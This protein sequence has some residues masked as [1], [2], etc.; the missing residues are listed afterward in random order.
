MV[1]S[2]PIIQYSW[3]SCK[4]TFDNNVIKEINFLRLRLF[5]PWPFLFT[6]E[7]IE[8]NRRYILAQH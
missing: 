4:K 5:D 6:G 1:T 8:V 2:V 3:Y 7:M